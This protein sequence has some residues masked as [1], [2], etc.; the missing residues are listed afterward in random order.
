M[1][2]KTAERSSKQTKFT[3]AILPEDLVLL[4]CLTCTLTALHLREVT[5]DLHISCLDQ[6]DTPVMKLF[7]NPLRTFVGCFSSFQVVDDISFEVCVHNLVTPPPPSK[8][9][10]F[11]S[12]LEQSFAG[13]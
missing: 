2:R 10:Y 13:I 1:S 9:A 7:K 3:I 4:A 11:L 8:Q 6:E 5:K 12:A